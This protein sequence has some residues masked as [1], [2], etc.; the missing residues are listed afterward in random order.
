MNYMK[1]KKFI[2]TPKKRLSSIEQKK[3]LTKRDQPWRGANSSKH[4]LQKLYPDDHKKK[5]NKQKKTRKKKKI[6]RTNKITYSPLMT[7]GRPNWFEMQKNI[8]P[9]VSVP[10]IRLIWIWLDEW[11]WFYVWN[12]MYFGLFATIKFSYWI[13]HG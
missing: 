8:F 2:I 6:G 10:L 1:I 3:C 11:G 12:R 13:R 7:G 5:K 4:H 9:S